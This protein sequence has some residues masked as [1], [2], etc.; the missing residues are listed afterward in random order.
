MLSLGALI[1]GADMRN[2]R[3]HAA[4]SMTDLRD[5]WESTSFALEMLQCNPTCVDQERLSMQSRMAPLA[6]S[7]EVALTQPELLSW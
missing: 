7:Y 5:R 1:R 3:I 4:T 2:Q 6:L